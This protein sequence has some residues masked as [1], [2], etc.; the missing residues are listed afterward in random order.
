MNASGNFK[1]LLKLEEYLKERNY[2]IHTEITKED[3]PLLTDILKKY[4]N[5]YYKEYILKDKDSEFKKDS[6]YYF[7][8][9]ETVNHKKH[10]IKVIKNYFMLIGGLFFFCGFLLTK[11]PLVLILMYSSLFGLLLYVIFYFTFF[12][13]KYNNHVKLLSLMI[14]ANNDVYATIVRKGN[15]SNEDLNKLDDIR[16][17][18]V[19][20]VK[21]LND[22]KMRLSLEIVSESNKK[23][24]E[25]H[26]FNLDS[27]KNKNKVH[28]KIL[29]KNFYRN[30]KDYFYV[31][32]P[33]QLALEY[34]YGNKKYL[35][36]IKLS[37]KQGV[38]EEFSTCMNKKINKTISLPQDKLNELIDYTISLYPE[39]KEYRELIIKFKKNKL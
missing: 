32:E 8:N 6:D 24:L 27:I 21:S 12:E 31:S 1:K 20:Y 19:N 11:L 15:Y 34:L 25:S 35:F 9:I 17:R 22:E 26:D 7:N 37:D 30:T 10:L 5:D 29:P 28:L 18:I 2:L 3:I 4:Y 33:S 39:D 38:F 13:I 36:L 16:Q 14:I 23:N